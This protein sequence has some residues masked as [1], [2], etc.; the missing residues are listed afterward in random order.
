MGNLDETDKFLEI[1]KLPKLTEEVENLNKEIAC[2]Q[3]YLPAGLSEEEINA[4]LDEIFEE[5]KQRIAQGRFEPVGAMY[6]EP[7][8]NV[9][10]CESLI[11]QCLYGQ[12]F[13][14]EKFGITVDN[15]WLPDVFGNSW[16][17]PQILK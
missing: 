10:S 14:R 4:K 13:F 2:L 7:D 15:C 5:L 1:H 6:V 3:Q 17:L 8:C 11:R 16:I 9:P 12:S